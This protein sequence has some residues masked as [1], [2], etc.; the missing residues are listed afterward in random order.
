M[1]IEKIKYNELKKDSN[2]KFDDG[3]IVEKDRIWQENF[4]KLQKQYNW[5]RNPIHRIGVYLT[6]LKQKYFTKGNSGLE[7]SI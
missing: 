6:N 4:Q 7:S 3:D 5:E 2:V 1:D